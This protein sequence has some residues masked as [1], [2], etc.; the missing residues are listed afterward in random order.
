M[1]APGVIACANYGPAP[2]GANRSFVNMNGAGGVH[3]P[4]AHEM[5]HSYGLHHVHVNSARAS[6]LNFLMNPVLLATQMTEPEKNAIIA[7]RA[8]GIR[9]G[10]TRNQALARVWSCR[11]PGQTSI[12]RE[13]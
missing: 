2:L 8:G 1:L 9:G 10:T 5:G 11:S 7:A 3:R 12:L 6:E 4:I 13:R